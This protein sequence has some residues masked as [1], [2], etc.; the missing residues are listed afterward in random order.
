MGY[1]ILGAFPSQ[2]CIYDLLG[3]NELCFVQVGSVRGSQWQVD[4]LVDL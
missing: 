2:L 4:E 1:T 3:K